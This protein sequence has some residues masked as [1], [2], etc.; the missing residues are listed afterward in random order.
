VA[1]LRR[2]HDPLREARVNVAAEMHAPVV[3]GGGETWTRGTVEQLAGR[4][5]ATGL[6]SAADIELFPT[7][8]GQRRRTTCR[9]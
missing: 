1:G 5:V 9:R 2:A 4:L 7:T 8:T 6:I 3:T